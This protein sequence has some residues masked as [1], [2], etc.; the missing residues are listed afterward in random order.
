[1]KKTLM[2]K[3]GIGFKEGKVCLFRSKNSGF[4]QSK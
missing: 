1:M 4:M 3:Q 2:K